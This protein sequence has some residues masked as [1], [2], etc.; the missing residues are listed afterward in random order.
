MRNWLMCLLILPA[1]LL[2]PALRAAAQPEPEKARVGRL[3]ADGVTAGDKLRAYDRLHQKLAD[4]HARRGEALAKQGSQ[5]EGKKELQRANGELLLSRQAYELALQRY[6]DH[7]LLHNYY[8][9]ILFDRFDEQEA[10]VGEWKKAIKLDGKLG[11]AHNNLGVFLCHA[12][13]YAEGLASLD[14][15][16]LLEPENPDY[17]YNIAQIYLAHWP[18]VM[19]IRK[20]TAGDLFKAAMTAS[21][22]ASRC[23]PDDF[24][25]AADYARNFFV[26]EEIGIA[27]DWDRAA[28]AW[29]RV[30]QLVRNDDEKFNAWLNEG[31][32]WYKANKAGRAVK[33]CDEAL[34]VR[35]QSM[36][37]EELK[38]MAREPKRP[39]SGK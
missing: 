3:L 4:I 37:A 13:G 24:E 8:G 27:P 39:K 17:Q 38:N 26:G 15:A 18:Q 20:W 14:K 25:L 12:G 1:A 7:A 28:K 6:P 34:K 33:C 9:E 2:C 31:R 21:E 30:R 5:E 19:E 11:R 22:T 23:A 32:V 36:V 29:Q 16:V 10:G 35:P